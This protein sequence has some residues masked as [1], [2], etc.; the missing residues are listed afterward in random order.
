RLPHSHVNLSCMKMKRVAPETESS[1]I[2]SGVRTYASK[3]TR[4]QEKEKSALS[5]KRPLPLK[6]KAGWGLGM[7]SGSA[8]ESGQENPN[9]KVEDLMS[10]LDR[11]RGGGEGGRSAAVSLA[12]AC[13]SAEV[14][15]VVCGHSLLGE[16][17]GSLLTIVRGDEAFDEALVY[18]LVVAIFLLS[19]DSLVAKTF[20]PSVVETLTAVLEGNMQ[21]RQEEN[22]MAPV[23]SNNRQEPKGDLAEKARRSMSRRRGTAPRGRSLEARTKGV[24]DFDSDGDGEGEGDCQGVAGSGKKDLEEDSEDKVGRDGGSKEMG[25]RAEGRQHTQVEHVSADV[26][27]RARMLLDLSDM[28]PWG[29]ANRHIVSSGDLALAALLNF[30]ESAREE[31]GDADDG[32]GQSSAQDS[33]ASVGGTTVSSQS[34]DAVE[35]GITSDLCCP[36]PHAILMQVLSAG[37]DTLASLVR[38][39]GQLVQGAGFAAQRYLHQ[40]LLALRLLDR[41]TL[42]LPSTSKEDSNDT[43]S[44]Q[45]M[46]LVR[47]ALAVVSRCQLLMARMGHLARS[48]TPAGQSSGTR[49]G[50]AK[51]TQIDGEEAEAATRIEDCLLAA[52]HVL[53]NVTH[54]DPSTCAAAGAAGGLASLL[55]CLVKQGHGPGEGGDSKG[56]VRIVLGQNSQH[57]YLAP[58]GRREQSR[59]LQ[60]HDK[61]TRKQVD[62]DGTDFDIQVLALGALINCVELEES[63][64]NRAAMANIMV[65]PATRFQKTSAGRS[66]CATPPASCPAPQFLAMFLMDCTH[67]FSDLLAPEHAVSGSGDEGQPSSLNTGGRGCG[68]ELGG[69]SRNCAPSTNGAAAGTSAARACALGLGLGAADEEDVLSHSEGSDLVLGGHCALLL[70]LLIRQEEKCRHLTLSILPDGSANL[71]VRVLEAFMALQ[72]QMGVLTEEV[73]LT[74]RE[75]VEDLESLDDS[76]SPKPVHASPKGKATHGH[77]E[78]IFR[79]S[80]TPT[81]SWSNS[82]SGR[83]RR[84][85]LSYPAGK[86]VGGDGWKPIPGQ[87]VDGLGEEEWSLTADQHPL[88]S[89]SVGQRRE[90]KLDTLRDG[91]EGKGWAML[92]HEEKLHQHSQDSH[93]VSGKGDGGKGRPTGLGLG[94]GAG[95][96]DGQPSEALWVQRAGGR[97]FSRVRWRQGRS[98]N[99]FRLPGLTEEG[100][101][102][103]YSEPKKSLVSAG[104]TVFDFSELDGDGDEPGPDTAACRAPRGGLPNENTQHGERAG[105]SD[106]GKG[107]EDREGDHGPVQSSQREALD[108]PASAF[109]PSPSVQECSRGGTVGPRQRGASSS[110]RQQHGSNALRHVDHCGGRAK[111]DVQGTQEQAMGQ[112]DD[113]SKGSNLGCKDDSAPVAK[114]ISLESREACTGSIARGA[115]RVRVGELRE[116][117]QGCKNGDV[118]EGQ[119]QRRGRAR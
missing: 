2:P 60:E 83:G 109:S 36:R 19:K 50:Q 52:L 24:F 115:V 119:S 28:L 94:A 34:E 77:A 53:M 7:S 18:C 68:G 98:L 108:C 69:K 10:L 8:S 95:R 61:S 67:E 76:L 22:A 17:T 62:H 118:R 70:G 107:G 5:T 91:Q 54:Q 64:E 113:G 110:R 43:S 63:A 106:N 114:G 23:G 90:T 65:S 80:I 85:G 97:M 112:G 117:A 21:S 15:S 33:A 25:S 26:F 92:T 78:R 55:E 93:R 30:A 1:D 75:L 57:D 87:W 35:E 79:G 29:L 31:P 46:E 105:M 86:V 102:G 99:G 72:S 9:L 73:V 104:S 41:A 45:R 96:R 74:V 6:G 16:L 44:T 89:L 39:R 48:N 56:K 32:R 20:P 12:K 51:D 66:Q 37:V 116:E 84:K 42:K 47:A 49:N 4:W 27:I 101:G 82:G 100:I 103:D 38:S 13:K 59:L 11:A 3:R 14:R 58:K 111:R 88:Q 71:I 81:L 40:L